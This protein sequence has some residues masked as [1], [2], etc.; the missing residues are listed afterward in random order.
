MN[1]DRRSGR[2]AGRWLPAGLLSLSVWAVAAGAPALAQNMQP[3]L[4]RLERLERDIRTLNQQISR[5]GS[6]P[7]AAAAAV[8]GGAA[9]GA[10]VSGAAYGRLDSRLATLED[11][12][13]TLT[14]RNEEI[15]HRLGQIETRLEKLASDVDYRLGVLEQGS[16]RP[17]A[18]EPQPNDVAAVPPSRATG[19]APVLTPPR[20]GAE[21]P[22]AG[23]APPGVLGTIPQSRID[24]QPRPGAAPAGNAPA[25]LDA[26]PAG[27]SRTAAVPPAQASGALPAG[28]PQEQYAYAQQFL[29][30]QKY[31]EA[32]RSFTAFIA[33][34]PN[35]PLTSNAR[36][37]LGETYYVRQD[38]E[39]AAVAF[40]E[41]WQKDQKGSKAPDSLLKLA[42]SL[43]NMK[44][45]KEA[46]AAFDKLRTDYPSAQGNVDRVAAKERQQAGCR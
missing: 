5:P 35:D 25:R 12:L 26:P 19:A 29:F 34:H 3:V 6:V 33:A 18:A 43:S 24:G 9:A 13:R 40:A 16:A 2:Q 15:M 27:A 36:Y 30:S 4:D 10:D 39:K 28:T 21:A 20:G 42:M 32:E 38:Y 22:L 7:P 41:G 44:K 14:G 46:C 8:G 17:T 1:A 23:A 31:A 37:W 45:S 11:D